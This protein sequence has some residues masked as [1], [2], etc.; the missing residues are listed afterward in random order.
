MKYQ[1]KKKVT[2][3]NFVQVKKTSDYAGF[4][5]KLLSQIDW[6]GSALKSHL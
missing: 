3:F 1:A 6:I 5:H 2:G 4:V